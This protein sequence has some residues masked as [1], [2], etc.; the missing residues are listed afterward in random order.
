MNILSYF[1]R[2]KTKDPSCDRSC[3]RLSDCQ[4]LLPFPNSAIR[5]WRSTVH[6]FR[7]RSDHAVLRSP[8]FILSSLIHLISDGLR[9]WMPRRSFAESSSFRCHP[10][11]PVS[12]L[13]GC[14]I[15]A[16]QPTPTMRV[17]R[18]FGYRVKVLLSYFKTFRFACQALNRKQFRYVKT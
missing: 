17:T 8:A 13:T 6:L 5:W 12:N 11:G 9:S 15:L 4:A 7:G 1:S 16:A 10:A 2:L 14:Q 18:K 3:C